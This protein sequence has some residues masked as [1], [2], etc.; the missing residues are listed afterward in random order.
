MLLKV[1]RT[2]KA[3]ESYTDSPVEF[4]FSYE[5]LLESKSSQGNTILL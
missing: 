1:D 5:S 4:T 3:R 2:V